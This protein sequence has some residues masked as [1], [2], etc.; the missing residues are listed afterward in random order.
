M[1]D[2]FIVYRLELKL[3][4]PA[5]EK[6]SN[7]EQNSASGSGIGGGVVFGVSRLRVL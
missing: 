5:H 6:T 2:C 3:G 7:R 4:D 1:K